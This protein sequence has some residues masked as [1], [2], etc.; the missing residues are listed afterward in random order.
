[1]NIINEIINEESTQ[2]ILGEC[3]FSDSYFDLEETVIVNDENNFDTPIELINS[4]LKTF[5]NN[6]KIAHINA[7]SLPKHIDEVKRLLLATDFDILAISETFIKTAT[8]K[9]LFKIGGYKF[10]HKD[11]IAK[12]G[13]GI[14][15]FVRDQIKVKLI[16]LPQV[17]LHPEVLFVELTINQTK[18]A[19]GVLYKPPKIPYGIFATMHETLAY[20]S[21][22]YTHNIILGDMNVNYLAQDSLPVNFFQTNITEP[23][24]LTQ[25][26]KDP[27]RITLTSSTLLDLI[28]VSNYSNVKKSGVVDVPGISDHCLVYM[29]YAIKKTKFIPKTV[30]RRDFRNFSEESFKNDM[31]LAP[32]GN[33]LAVREEEV[34]NQVTI[35]ENIFNEIIDRHAPFRTFTIKQPP[36]PW[37]TP[38]IKSL[39]DLRDKEKN[40]FNITKNNDVWDNFVSLRNRVNHAIRASKKK[41]FSD[42]V[43]SKVKFAK[44]YHNALKRLNVVDSKH[45]NDTCDYDSDLLNDT[46]TVNNNLLVDN[47]SI[48]S[49]ISDIFNNI[50]YEGAKFKFRE[51]TEEQVIKIVKSIK[52]NATGIDGISAYF[53]KLSIQSS[54]YAITHIIN[55]SFKYRYFPSRWKKAVIK[56]LPKSENPTCASEFR[57][58]SLL[59]A[60]SKIS[61]KIACHQM[62]TFFASNG[63]LDDLQSAYKLYHGTTTALLNVTDDIYKALDKSELSI[64]VLLDY[65]KAFDCANHR[66]I[67]AKLKALGFHDESLAWVVSYLTDRSQKVKTDK[68]ESRWITLI[69]GVPQGSVLGPLFF[70]VLISDI[71]KVIKNG[72]YHLYADDTQLYYHCKVD[73]IINMVEK[74]NV[75]LAGVEKFSS[76]NCLKLN[77]AKSNFIVIGSPANLAKLKKI[78][79]PPLLINKKEIE[80]KTHV[81]N[82]GM[83]FDEVL[84]WTK[85]VNHLV[86]LAYYKLKQG[87]RAKNFLSFEAKVK[88]CESYILSHFNYCDVVYQNISEFLKRKIQKV[89]NSCLRFIYGLKKYDHIS[90]CLISLNTLNMNERRSLH[91][92]TLIHKINIG[93]A[94]TY[95]CQRIIHHNEIHN[96]NTRNRQNIINERTWTVKRQMSFFPKFIKLYNEISKE[97]NVKDISVTTFKKKS[98]NY[99][100]KN[101][102]EIRN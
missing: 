14:G 77:A 15:L 69:N 75:D 8:P 51:I 4:D 61:E 40:K 22:K 6:L 48:T 57:P 73:N 53:I 74:I 3:D 102:E 62:G 13:G 28:L 93:Q 81:K 94:P 76:N 92:L 72:K 90:K 60:L 32:W 59:P 68:S 20:I 12:N 56:P 45:L 67:L 2:V 5:R 30:T 83:T 50:N 46:F 35:I 71:S 29:A 100:L 42:E 63:L 38:S 88:L 19:V 98:K 11:R 7:R 96:Y 101:R 33:V 21:T 36:T 10:F 65:S 16:N 82:L 85:H 49:E 70:T 37:L 55:S 41:T 86:G 34:D 24:N 27:T 95:L 78:I 52:T 26:I 87:Y 18:I 80:R 17:I 23:F 25:I 47:V 66:L 43:N 99:L 58:I 84:S 64:L 44:Q 1:M 89:Q 91:G 54:V 97:F 79:F 31:E 39:M 9:H